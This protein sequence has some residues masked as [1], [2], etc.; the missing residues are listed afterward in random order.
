VERVAGS[1]C[2]RRTVCLTVAWV[3]PKEFEYYHSKKDKP[4]PQEMLARVDAKG[5]VR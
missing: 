4:V 3:L 5:K 2:V 1:G